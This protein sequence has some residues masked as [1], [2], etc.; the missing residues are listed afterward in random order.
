MFKKILVSLM[1]LGMLSACAKTGIKYQP[2][3]E[4]IAIV[5]SDEIQEIPGTLSSELDETEEAQ[6]TLIKQEKL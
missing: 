1:A 5:E 3:A 4:E 2:T 6:E